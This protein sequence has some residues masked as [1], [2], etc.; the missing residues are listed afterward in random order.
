MKT[1]FV[2]ETSFG[3]ARAS[4]EDINAS[5]VGFHFEPAPDD[6]KA[7]A[8]LVRQHRVQG[9]IAD[10]TPYKGPLYEALGRG[11]VISRYGVGHD[12]I[13]KSRARRAGVTVCNTPGVLDNAVAEHAVWML[14][15]LARPVAK[16]YGE[17][18]GGK[19]QPAEGIEVRGRNVTVLGCG[20][21]GRSLARKL[22]IGLGMVVTGYDILEAP[23][24]GED[25]GFTRYTNQLDRAL[26]DAD[27][28]ICLLPVLDATRHIAN[29]GFFKQMKQGARFINSARGALVDE[30]DL[31]DALVS[32]HLSGA[33]LDV[34]EREPYQP[35]DAEKDLR[36]LPQVILT[37]HIGSNTEESNDAMARMA[38]ENVIT[39][40]TQ[41]PKSCPNLIA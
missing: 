29:A 5:Q 16:A 38:A 7:L 39:C 1:V 26:A 18:H 33:A 37:P 27:F 20:R 22:G 4:F 12:S 19:W 23:H 34:F 3:K 24:F 15:A 14:G 11:G 40:L 21:I 28:V 6:E 31:Y 9:F 30:P 17:M 25:S 13:D 10:L 36:S 32:G 35:S 2:S 8:A 41:G